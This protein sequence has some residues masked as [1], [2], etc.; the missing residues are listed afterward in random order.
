MWIGEI[1]INEISVQQY[2]VKEESNG[3][4]NIIYVTCGYSGKTITLISYR[5]IILSRNKYHL[6]M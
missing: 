4:D 2:L 3:D 5:I 6:R 1:N